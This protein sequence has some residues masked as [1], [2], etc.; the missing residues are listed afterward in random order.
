MKVAVIT[1]AGSGIGLAV[2]QLLA[3]KGYGLVLAGRKLETLENAAATAGKAGAAKVV[4]IPT[5]LAY[6]SQASELIDK[7]FN[8][9]Q[10]IDV[11]I[12]NAGVASLESMGE[13]KQETLRVIFEINTFGPA[14]AI[15]RVW[16]IMKDQQQHADGGA[17]GVRGRI[18]NI[19][20]L[21]TKDPFPGFFAYA[22]SK[23]ALNSFTRSIANEGRA[24]GILGFAVAPGAVETG[25][26]RASFDEKMIPRSACLAAVEV[27]TVIVDCAEGLRDQDNGQVIWLSKS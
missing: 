17:G 23:A 20:T 6:S 27:G 11:L 22:A 18:I 15:G 2:T 16:K 21:G 14:A 26:L 7:A 13:V 5:D 4:V 1:G 24:V 19:S 9:F 12:N 3:A 25:M 10:R 8:E